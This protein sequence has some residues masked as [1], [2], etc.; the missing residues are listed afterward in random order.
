[1]TDFIY[2][3]END[4]IQF[5]EEMSKGVIELTCIGMVNILKYILGVQGMDEEVH[6]R[7]FP[8][9]LIPDEVRMQK[10]CNKAMRENPAAFFFVP[11]RF[12]TQEMCE[13]V[14]E[15]SPWHLKHVPDHLKTQEMWKKVVDQRLYLV[16]HVPDWFVTQR[17]NPWH[18]DE[19]IGRHE[20][21]KIR[22]VQ[23]SQI[24]KE[25][26]PVAWHPSWHW[27]WCMSEDEK[28]ETEKLWT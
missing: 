10:M 26:M 19:L 23:K 15:R 12:K 21:Y 22:K 24:K 8:F 4:F 17:V 16:Q 3:I 6:I 2:F 11:D 7:S 27:D 13:K 5:I 1:M 28:K 25:L 18:N 9:L 20:G 14:V